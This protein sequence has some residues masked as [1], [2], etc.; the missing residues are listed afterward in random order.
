MK[1]HLL[2]KVFISHSSLDK[3]FV[4]RLTRRL[5]KEGFRVWLDER[6]LVAGDSLGKKNKRSARCRTRCISCCVESFD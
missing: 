4:R 5:E 6:E 3:P 2:G 1:K